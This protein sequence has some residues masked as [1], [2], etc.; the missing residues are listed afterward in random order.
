MSSFR[1]DR[2]SLPNHDTAMC[3]FRDG[4]VWWGMGGNNVCGGTQAGGE[5][6][7]R[8]GKASGGKGQWYQNHMPCCSCRQGGHVD[9]WQSCTSR[10]M[11]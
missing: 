1:S 10:R 8:P 5:G 2:P 9:A 6:Q 4:F 11:L 3:L 7:L